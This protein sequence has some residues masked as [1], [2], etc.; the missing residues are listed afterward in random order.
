MKYAKFRE[1]KTL[2]K[3]SEFTVYVSCP[4]QPSI[5][6]ELPTLKNSNVK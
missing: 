1:I 3:I 2:A 6:F 4:F 5:K